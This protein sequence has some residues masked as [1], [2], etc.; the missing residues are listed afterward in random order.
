MIC[1]VELTMH[2]GTVR[3]VCF[4]EDT[5]NKTSLLVSGGAGDCKIYVT[6]CATGKTFQVRILFQRRRSKIRTFTCLLIYLYIITNNFLMFIQ[7]LIYIMCFW[8]GLEIFQRENMRN[9]KQIIY[10]FNAI[11]LHYFNR[12]HKRRWFSIGLLFCVYI[13][14]ETPTFE[15]RLRQGTSV[16]SPFNFEENILSLRLANQ[17]IIRLH[18]ISTNSY[19]FAAKFGASVVVSV[20][21]TENILLLKVSKIGDDCDL[22][23]FTH[24]PLSD[25]IQTCGRE[26]I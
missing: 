3:D 25:R 10:Q 19:C 16:A 21:F 26:M 20:K 8:F 12:L 7:H 22:L 9:V 23:I 2:D 15:I 11:N 13:L 4:I 6:D 1:Q 5:S 14:C 17:G 18:R 24:L